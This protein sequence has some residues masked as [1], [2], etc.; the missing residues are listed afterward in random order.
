MEK[1]WKNFWWIIIVVAVIGGFIF[2]QSNN[3]QNQVSKVSMETEMEVSELRVG[4]MTS[5]AEGALP[6]EVMRESG[7]AEKND[8]NIK[9]E[10]FQ[11]GPPMVEAAL[12]N[13]IDLFFVGWVPAVNLMTK[14]DD[15]MIIGK[16]SYFPMEVMARTDSGISKITDLEGKR[17]GIPYATGPYPVVINSLKN[18]DLEP[19]KDVEI[20]NIKP[21]EMGA[22]LQTS[23]VDAI[24]WGEPM[25]TLFKQKNL[26]Y[27]IEEY[28]DISFILISK[29]FAE[30]NPEEVKK[31]MKAFKESQFYLSENKKQAFEWFSEESQFDISLVESLKFNEPNFNVKSI[32]DVDMSISQEWIEKTQ[33]KIDFEFSEKIIDKKI[34]IKENID[35]SYLF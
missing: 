10:K 5:W 18:S 12:A 7:I 14:S 27:T 26:A 13:K 4:Y 3:N 15:W 2:W 24:A 35:Q 32:E 21:T 1:F 28:D 11:Y 19:G 16:N 34:N 17:L 23:Q 30:K 9:Y 29:T 20:V 33:E 8:L 31:F 22:A 25:L 6:S